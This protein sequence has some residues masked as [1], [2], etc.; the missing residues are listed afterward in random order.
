MYLNLMEARNLCKQLGLS[1]KAIS[2]LKLRPNME[3][4]AVR[5]LANMHLN[6]ANRRGSKKAPEKPESPAIGQ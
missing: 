5:L 3:E 2:R 6:L 4:S 1:A